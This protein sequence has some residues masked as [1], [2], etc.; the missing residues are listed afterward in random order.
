MCGVE[1]E[2]EQMHGE[3]AELDVNIPAL[4][5]RL[6]VALPNQKDLVTLASVSADR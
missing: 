3:T 6:E 5:E 2:A 4:G 1:V